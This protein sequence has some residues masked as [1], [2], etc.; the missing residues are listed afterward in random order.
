MAD[1]LDLHVVQ[2]FP[3][4][5]LV[6]DENGS[7]KTCV[8]GGTVRA[9]RSSQSLKRAVRTYLKQMDKAHFGGVRTR[10]LAGSIQTALLSKKVDPTLASTLANSIAN[11]YGTSDEE[12][13]KTVLFFS[14]GEINA[15]AEEVAAAIK[16]DTLDKI[17]KIEKEKD[18]KEL[19]YTCQ[20]GKLLKK[21]TMVD[22][23]DIELFGR[24]VASDTDLFVEGSTSFSHPLSVHVCENEVDFFAAVD[25]TAAKSDAGSGHIGEVEYNSACYYGCVSINLNIFNGSRLAALSVQ[26]RRDLLKLFVEACIVAPPSARHN[27]MFAAT[28][29]SAVLGLLRKNTFPLSLANAFETPIRPSSNGYTAEA[30][31]RLE[32]ELEKTKKAFGKR[33]GIVTE[34]W[35]PDTDLDTF[36]GGLTANV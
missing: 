4:S 26:T 35:F 2:S 9:R 15:M 18:S 27:S 32:V 28:L 11:L 31:K 7:P 22:I 30:R 17:F 25:E 5:C 20:K 36:S 12:K 13:T 19:K 16:A 24:M 10:S 8:F 34:T 14:E 33:L 3:V 21:A 23:G 1:Y 6:R 29:P